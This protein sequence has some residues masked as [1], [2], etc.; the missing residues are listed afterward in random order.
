MSWKGLE[1]PCQS[2]LG[3]DVQLYSD[4]GAASLG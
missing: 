3:K 4:Q 2:L 1:N